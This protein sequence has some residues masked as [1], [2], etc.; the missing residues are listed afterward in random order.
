MW[1]WDSAVPAATGYCLNSR[2]IG[3]AIPPGARN[4]SLIYSVQTGSGALPA[5]YPV[6]TE[7][8]FPGVKEV[9]T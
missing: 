8:Y 9:G 3:V 1:S 6:G 2:F 7:G 5:S 4:F